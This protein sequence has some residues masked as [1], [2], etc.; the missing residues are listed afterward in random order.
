MA[1]KEIFEA[2]EYHLEE[3]RSTLNQLVEVFFPLLEQVMV[4]AGNSQ[5]GNQILVM[6]LISKIF[7][8]ANNVS[9]ASTPNI[10]L[11]AG[12]LA[13][14][15][16]DAVKDHILDELLPERLGDQPGPRVRDAH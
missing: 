5:S 12:R 4:D 11:I 13:L 8:S 1:L 10:F 15:P 16:G 2:N 9:D 3:D 6:H 7:F 14:L